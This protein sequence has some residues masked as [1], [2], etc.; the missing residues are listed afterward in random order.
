MFN[1]RSST[2]LLEITDFTDIFTDFCSTFFSAL[3]GGCLWGLVG[4][5]AYDTLPNTVMNI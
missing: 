2:A 3:A 1:F 4:G 5:L